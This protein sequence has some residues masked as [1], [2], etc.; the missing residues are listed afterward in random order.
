MLDGW[1]AESQIFRAYSPMDIEIVDAP[2]NLLFSATFDAIGEALLGRVV[3]SVDDLRVWA[4]RRDRTHRLFQ[5]FSI[6][7]T[8]PVSS[9]TGISFWTAFRE[10]SAAYRSASEDSALGSDSSA[11]GDCCRGMVRIGNR[12]RTFVPPR[13][14]QSGIDGSRSGPAP[15]LASFPVTS[16]VDCWMQPAATADRPPCPG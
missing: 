11:A 5:T 13:G 16:E 12:L 4:R 6:P 15:R 2:G 7:M 3:S 9:A 10:A 1:L 8:T 14:G